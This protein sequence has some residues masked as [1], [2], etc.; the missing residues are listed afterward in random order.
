MR[1]PYGIDLLGNII[2]AKLEDLLSGEGDEKVVAEGEAAAEEFLNPNETVLNLNRVTK[3]TPLFIIHG[4]GGGV[5]LMQKFALAANLPMPVY[6][7]QDTPSAPIDGSIE[8]L[9]EFYVEKIVEKQSQGPYNLAGFSFG[10]TVVYQIALLFQQRGETVDRLLFLDHAPTVFSNRAFLEQTG[11][12]IQGETLDAEILSAVSGIE[13]AKCLDGSDGME[14]LFQAYFDEEKAGTHPRSSPSWVMRFVEAYRAHMRMALQWVTDGL[15]QLN[16]EGLVMVDH[17]DAVENAKVTLIK[18]TY[19]VAK[20]WPTV[21]NN[22]SVNKIVTGKDR[23]TVVELET[24]HFGIWNPDAG[25]IDGVRK[26]MAD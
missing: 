12:R 23:L 8:E 3:G 17:W 16:D 18:A 26:A 24:T 14:A 7:V 20:D 21:E 5:L 19:G 4:A 2:L 15:G 22:F 13:K 11:V 1:K 9:A 6:G 25:L 10:A